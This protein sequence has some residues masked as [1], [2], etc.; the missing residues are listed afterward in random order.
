MRSWRANDELYGA[1]DRWVKDCLIEDHSLFS[2]GTAIWEP[3]TVDLVADRIA[4]VDSGGGDFMSK[5]RGQVGDLPPPAIQL[6]AELLF[7]HYLAE[8]DTGQDAKLKN[9]REV[10]SWLPASIEIPPELGEACKSGVAS[11]GGAKRNRDIYV[12]FLCL[13]CRKVKALNRDERVRI[14]NDPWAL[15]LFLKAIPGSS[16]MQ[17]EA[18]LHLIYPDTFEA[19]LAPEQKRQIVDQFQEVPG[20]AEADNVDAK[21]AVIRSALTEVVGD[22]F[23]FYLDVIKRVWS[24]PQGPWGELVRWVRRLLD[25]PTFVEKEMTYKLQV[26][27]RLALARE[28]LLADGEDWPQLL[29]QAFASPNNLTSFY[30]HAPFLEW[31]EINPEVAMDALRRLWNQ[32][33]P[34][35]EDLRSF[36]EIIPTD[37]I[38]APGGK[39]NITSFL[40]MGRDPHR[41][42]VYKPD[43]GDTA[44][45]LIGREVDKPAV[46]ERYEAFVEFLDELRVRI[47]AAGGAAIDRLAAQGAIWWVTSGDIPEDWT[48]QDQAALE[49]FR[50]GTNPNVSPVIHLPERAWLVRGANVDDHNPVSE[51]I[52]QGFVSIGWSELGS[53]PETSRDTL[54]RVVSEVY[55][56]DLPGGQRASVGNLHRF[57]N[58]MRPGHLVTTIDGDRVY[59]GRISGHVYEDAGNPQ[60]VRRRPVEWL[61]SGDPASRAQIQV[62]Y[63]TLYSRMRALLT[64]TD[65]KEDVAS[66]AALAGLRTPPPPPLTTLLEATDE[67]A[68]RVFLPREWLQG[69]VVDLLAD[70]RQLIFYGPP[71]T[72]KTF[73]AQRIAE[74]LT[75][76]GGE[77]ELVQFHPSYSYEDFFEGFRPVSVSGG[78]GVTYELTPGPLRRIA[79]AAAQDPSHPYILVIDEINRGNLPKIF[80]ELLFLLEYREAQI[81]LQYSPESQFGLPKNLYLVGTMNTADRSIALV[82][83]ALRRRFYFVA[84]RPTEAPIADVLANWLGEKGFD[85]RPSQLLKLLNDRIADEDIAIGPSYFM[86]EDSATPAL[87][88]IWKHAIMPVLEEHFYGTDRNLEAEF[89]LGA[90]DKALNAEAVGISGIDASP[91]DASQ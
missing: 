51:W 81:P 90:L 7:M 31:V 80:G 73:V 47:V 67:L 71:G 21:L 2:P 76:A 32:D 59:V 58:V 44:I 9:V 62:D 89:G 8:D 33:D 65:L 83:A 4:I 77:F 63:P 38:S 17:G 88:R 5:L 12:R 39:A 6:S 30:Q 20:V 41:Y 86:T 66:V 34:T 57:L 49:A 22:G 13:F 69:E 78:T 11:Y 18:L 37:V 14:M 60:S 24:A 84:F 54:M 48:S 79:E 50:A 1:A 55:P 3:Q 43:P 10:L 52:E 19:I 29:R 28:A 75:R 16:V 70:K 72:G 82:D 25:E 68:A 35:H 74:H 53:L 64:V 56:E 40:L 26:A 36:V 15:R 91:D 61:N 87:A 42:P 85:Q 23:P 45:K 46:V 27:G